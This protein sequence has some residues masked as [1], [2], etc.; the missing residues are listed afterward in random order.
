M[1]AN[2]LTCRN[3]IGAGWQ[4]PCRDCQGPLK[5]SSRKHDRP[6]GS[7]TVVQRRGACADVRGVR[8][9]CFASQDP[10]TVRRP[11]M[12]RTLQRERGYSLQERGFSLIE[13]MVTIVVFGLLIGF[14]VPSYQSYALTQKLRGTSENLVQMIQLQ[15]SRA[16]ATGQNVV[17]NFNTAAPAGWTVMS[18]A[19][20]NTTALPNGIT[21]ASANPNTI[22]LTRDGR[23]NSSG[24]FVFQNRTG[25]QDTVSV[26]L[27][28]LAL[29]R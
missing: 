26:Q 4:G 10:T 12:T 1:R 23:V 28:G 5:T 25:N 17:I 29:I 11:I 2:E 20:S 21:Y 3:S 14:S 16:M 8:N 15:R 24:L 6:A 7:Q 9:S 22:T 27:S 13:L 18:G 19:L